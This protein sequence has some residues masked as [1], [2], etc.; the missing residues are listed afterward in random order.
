MDLLAP[1][2]AL[3]LGDVRNYSLQGEF[4]AGVAVAGTPSG[5]EADAD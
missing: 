1:G 4:Q 3:F 2:G 5:A